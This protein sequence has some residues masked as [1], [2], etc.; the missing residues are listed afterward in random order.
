M[1]NTLNRR[2]FL[3]CTIAG[4]AAAAVPGLVRAQGYG[5]A[6][7]RALPLTDRITLIEGAGT[8]VVVLAGADGVVLV[9][10]GLRGHNAELLEFVAALGGPSPRIEAL[11]NSNWRAEHTGL[12]AHVNGN[13]G[14]TIAHMNTW[15][16]MG[17]DFTVDWENLVHKPQPKEELP[18]HTFYT[19][20]S[21]DFGGET[22]RYAH[23]MQAHTDGDLY[24]HFPD[25]NVLVASDLLA[26]N[27]YPVV[28]YVT[29][30]WIGGLQRAT[31]ALLEIADAST[32]IVPAHGPIQRR[33][34]LEKQ[35]EFCAA[36]RDTVGGMIKNGRS[37]EEVIEAQPTR[38]FDAGW[39]GDTELFLRLAYQGLYGH[40]RELGGVL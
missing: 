11:F 10:G 36:M 22:V 15:L 29:G 9:D 5:A 12:N 6:P 8:N 20:E 40:I 1:V 3:H 27:A 23:L 19:E 7:L 31:Q 28:D 18:S 2:G 4:A 32:L 17:N 21:F 13:G 39:Q 34:A 16:W 25:S 37:L 38:A 30:G 26:V 14:R 24:V 35:L 33:G